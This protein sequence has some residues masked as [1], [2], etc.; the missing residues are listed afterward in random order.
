MSSFEHTSSLEKSSMTQRVRISSGFEI[1]NDRSIDRNP[2]SRR[3]PRNLDIVRK[4]GPSHEVN[5]FVKNAKKEF[6]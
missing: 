1:L 2:M 3:L 6:T 5:N 4:T